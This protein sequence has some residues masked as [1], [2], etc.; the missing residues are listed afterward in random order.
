MQ[1][2]IITGQYTSQVEI[3]LR[4]KD[5]FYDRRN[6]DI[7]EKLSRRGK[8]VANRGNGKG[9]CAFTTLQAARAVA[10][11]LKKLIRKDIP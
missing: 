10:V 2:H 4:L 7:D 5:G 8:L 1:P 9:G 6:N 11:W 3:K